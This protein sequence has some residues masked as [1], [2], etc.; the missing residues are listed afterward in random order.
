MTNRKI[1]EKL[2]QTKGIEI[3][4]SKL[5]DQDP[6]PLP[7][8]F[9]FDRIEGMMLGLAIGDALGITTE[10]MIPKDRHGHYG[11]IR[12]YLPNRHV[13]LLQGENALGYPSDDTQLAFWTLEQLIEDSG[14]N[15]EHVARRFCK[16]R[17][18][19]IGSAVRNFVTAFQRGIGWYRAGQRSAGNGALMRI[20]PILIPHLL[21][22]AAELWVDTALCA[23]I[24]HNDTASIS[25]CLAFVHILWELLHRDR[26][27]E[28]SWWVREYI[29]VARELETEK[30]YHPRGGIHSDY[31]GPLSRFV[32]EKIPTTYSRGLSVMDACNSWY[33][34]A[35]LLETVPSVLYI[36]M[37]HGHDFEQAVL[38]AVNDTKDNDT[39]A[40][41]VGAAAGALNGKSSIP[42]RWI[43]NL[44]GRTTDRDDG[45]IFELLEQA[46]DRWAR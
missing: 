17:I 13:K 8:D 44:S 30:N 45:R 43:E 22:P 9:D 29:T 19:G 6:A 25:A 46:A 12:G 2:F 31:H 34:G 26:P 3:R 10:G 38:R 36:L 7:E 39:I 18:F 24:T 5:F 15:P 37:K 32:I 27:P 14:F 4:R 35:F 20:A 1:L 40:A 11:E 42:R 41:I 23:I 16:S 33:S 28:P 21:H